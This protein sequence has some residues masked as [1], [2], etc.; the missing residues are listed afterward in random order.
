MNSSKKLCVFAAIVLLLLSTSSLAQ[1]PQMPSLMRLRTLPTS[2]V[3]V[4]SAASDG[5]G[6]HLVG[7]LSGSVKHFLIDNAGNE[8]SGY[9]TTVASGG[10]YP[11]VT[12]Y[13]GK[14]RVT[15]KLNNNIAVYQSVDGGVNW[16]SFTPNPSVGVSIFDID[17][18][19]DD[20]G[21]H[22]VWATASGSTNGEVYYVRYDE[23]LQD[24]AG[25]KN[26]TDISGSDVGGQPKVATT[27]NEAHV[28]FVNGQFQLMSRDLDLGSGVWDASYADG[29]ENRPP[30]GINL[31]TIADSVYAMFWTII[32]L[33]EELTT[34]NH[35]TRRHVNDATWQEVEDLVFG[36]T[37]L[38]QLITVNS[39]LRFANIEQEGVTLRTYT[40]EEGWG[41][42]ETIEAYTGQGEQDWPFI[43][44]SQH[45]T[46]VFFSG[47]SPS[48]HQHM[49]RKPHLITGNFEDRTLLSDSNWVQGTT[50]INSTQIISNVVA[51]VRASAFLFL[52]DDTWLN[53]FGTLNV[54]PGG[55]V[56]CGT[57]AEIVIRG[58]EVINNGTIECQTAGACI[59]VGNH[60]GNTG[61]FV[62]GDDITHTFSGGG[63]IAIDGG[64]LS[65]GSR[66]A[67]EVSSES[68]IV[69][70]STSS[71]V[72]G[73]D[74]RIDLRGLADIRDNTTLAL[75][76]GSTFNAF[77]GAIFEMGEGASI[78]VAGNLVVEG[79]PEG[80]VTFTRSGPTGT[81]NGIA[82]TGGTSTIS[83]ADIS[84]CGT[85]V[86]VSGNSALTME[87]CTVSN[88]SI[89]VE[90]YPPSGWLA[91]VR[92]IRYCTFDVTG[93]GVLVEN[94]SDLLLENNVFSPQW[95]A[96]FGVACIDASPTLLLNTIEGFLDGLLAV[97]AS[98]PVL[99]DGDLGGCNVITSNQVGV[100]CQ[101]GASPN[102]GFFSE[103]GDEGGLNS[104]FGNASYDIHIGEGE[105]LLAHN[106]YWTHKDDPTQGFSCG[107]SCRIEYEP[108]LTEPPECGVS[109]MMA[110]KGW[111]GTEEPLHN[112]ENPLL[113]L[114]M[115]HRG[116]REYTQAAGVLKAMVA[117]GGLPMYLRRWAVRQLLAVSQNMR[118]PGLPAYLTAAITRHPELAREM[119]QVL[120]GGYLHEG[121]TAAAMAAYDANMQLYPNSG[122]E[123]SAL[124]GK[125][126]H[127]L[128]RIK[129][130]QTAS[131][132]Y[133]ELASKYP[134]SKEQSIAAV[135]LSNAAPASSPSQKGGATGKG[136]GSGSV[137]R[138]GTLPAEFALA[139]NFPNPFNPTTQ[140]NFDLPEPAT[141]RLVI[142]D[143][144]GRE[145]ATLVHGTREAGY[146][147][148]TWS[149][150]DVASG[151]YFARFTAMDAE[152][153]LR[154]SKVSKLLLT[155]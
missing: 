142:Y 12:S 76:T 122:L 22:I 68:K 59:Y 34:Y 118:S 115:R 82:I 65:L 18:Y 39:V 96:D 83:Y 109:K 117:N 15:M 121:N 84:Y 63:F 131:A 28:A 64:E 97:G 104:I 24:F 61:R 99:E 147:S 69:L 38:R 150:V 146:H 70:L 52:Q 128:Y 155:K 31:A 138:T 101:E 149:A 105:P 30:S 141:V 56:R 91:F 51:D 13:G 46:Y 58:G 152:G 77:E 136:A 26:V 57:G 17:A 135:Q 89:G 55:T 107:G 90:V 123:R 132:L 71:F 137:A 133:Q 16:T 154:L 81:W 74:S 95:G 143:V 129:D 93:V 9:T 98:S 3:G 110:G 100:T 19:S 151:I 6:Q 44:A 35:F 139:Q 60:G 4:T 116:K 32:Q 145:V 106:N 23:I 120:P 103:L 11:V 37:R 86:R 66:A 102:L 10:E 126:L 119:R 140:I 33:E 113:T 53:V 45:G 47:S 14:L 108:W 27:A 1:I 114:A 148:V 40:Q 125:F 73:G 127:A 43:S 29:P 78:N 62:I 130:G 7:V 92:E 72:F 87:H 36:T 153:A 48:P 25:L 8:V 42:P 134:G 5:Y 49:R 111:F 2:V 94:Y 20:Y 80:K 85:A 124:Y 112:R 21:T 41:S 88:V 50:S 67:V 54:N 144:L 79:S 75:P